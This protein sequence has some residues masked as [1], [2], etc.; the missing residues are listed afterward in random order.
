MMRPSAG[1]STLRN[2]ARRVAE[3][4]EDEGERDPREKCQDD[5]AQR[6]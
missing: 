6:G 4:L 3:E 5:D 1:D 2:R